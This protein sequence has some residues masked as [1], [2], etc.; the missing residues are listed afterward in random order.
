MKIQYLRTKPSRYISRTRTNAR[1]SIMSRI[2]ERESIKVT[3]NLV[4]STKEK[5]IAGI[6]TAMR[7]RTQTMKTTKSVFILMCSLFF[8][9]V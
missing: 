1:M 5:I 4:L 8:Q 3:M 9:T 7:R 2:G 6:T